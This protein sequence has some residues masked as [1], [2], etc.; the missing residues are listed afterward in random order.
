MAWGRNELRKLSEDKARAEKEYKE[1]YAGPIPEDVARKLG[2]SFFDRL[3]GDLRENVKQKNFTRG[4]GLF[5]SCYYEITKNFKLKCADRLEDSSRFH[6]KHA[7]FRE[8]DYLCVYIEEYNAHLLYYK[9]IAHVKS[10]F[11][12]ILRLCRDSGLPAEYRIDRNRHS[13][14]SVLTFELRL[15]CDKNGI[16][17]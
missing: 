17:K 6:G 12:R 10:V 15:P 14:G 7:F 4:K 13:D 8:N 1:R 9:N 16:V 11:D 3:R 2:E 5:S